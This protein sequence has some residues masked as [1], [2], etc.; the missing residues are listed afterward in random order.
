MLDWMCAGQKWSA[1]VQRRH[2]SGSHGGER[3]GRET[4]HTSGSASTIRSEGAP[5]SFWMQRMREIGRYRLNQPM[6]AKTA[7]KCPCLLRCKW[8]GC[9]LALHCNCLPHHKCAPASA[10]RSLS[11]RVALARWLRCASLLVMPE[12]F[13]GSSILARVVD[14]VPIPFDTPVYTLRVHI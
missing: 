4:E 13:S 6:A 5:R 12:T 3:R 9:S 7:P 2:L 1:C 14:S 8:I 10:P 11:A